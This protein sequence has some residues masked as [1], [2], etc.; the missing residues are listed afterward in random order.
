MRYLRRRKKRKLYQQWVDM[1]NLPS[2]AVPRERV[3][4]DRMAPQTGGQQSRMTVLYILLGIA[5]IVLFAGVV[6]LFVYS[7]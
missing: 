2:D 4:E 7:G 3:A 5:I 6:L 1:A